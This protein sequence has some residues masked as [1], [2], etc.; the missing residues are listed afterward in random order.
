MR[1]TPV[2]GA[3]APPATPAPVAAG[4]PAVLSV[5][6]VGSS[7]VRM[8]LAELR[9]EGS[10]RVLEDVQKPLALGRET[11]R[12]GT[13]SA[14]SI[15][16]AVNILRQYRA[17]MD[18]YG[19]THTRAVATSAVRAALNRD[20]SVARVSLATGIEVEVIEGSQE[21]LLTFAAVQRAIAA[22]PEPMAG[23]SLMFELG[24]GSTE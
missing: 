13:L 7:G 15:Q 23:D 22:R 10:V 4:A 8:L 2:T 3:G 19:V 21:T 9:P 24:A 11:F 16:K 20:T 14:A 18:S 17:M 12:T 5:I 1:E 6:D